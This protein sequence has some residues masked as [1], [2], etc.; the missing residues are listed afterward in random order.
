MVCGVARS[1]ACAVALLGSCA[2]PRG[3]DDAR[4]SA[5][6]SRPT[7][8]DVDDRN[9]PTP[10]KRA[11]ACGPHYQHQGAPQW[12]AAIPSRMIT[13]TRNRKTATRVPMSSGRILSFGA[14]ALRTPASRVAGT[15]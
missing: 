12:K 5:T 3:E 10:R 8:L 13:K 7:V 11:D 15:E 4:A 6:V 2:R 9:H 1:A 14:A